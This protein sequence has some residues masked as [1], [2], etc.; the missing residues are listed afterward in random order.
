M[1]AVLGM[2]FLNDYYYGWGTFTFT[3]MRR[4]LLGKILNPRF[5]FFEKDQDVQLSVAFSSTSPS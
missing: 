1:E 4:A 2:C 5:S 3:L